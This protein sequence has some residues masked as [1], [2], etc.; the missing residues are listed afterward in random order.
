MFLFPPPSYLPSSTSPFKPIPRSL[1]HHLLLS[2][3]LSVSLSL[4]PLHYL[5]IISPST[6]LSL[7]PSPMSLVLLLYP[8][9]FMTV[10]CLWSLNSL[11]PSSKNPRRRCDPGGPP[12]TNREE[13][14]DRQQ[15]PRMKWDRIPETLKGTRI[16]CRWRDGMTH[17]E[18]WVRLTDHELSGRLEREI[19][20]V[21]RH[22]TT[23]PQVVVQLRPCE[24]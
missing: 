1:C 20:P 7:P 10:I 2:T 12:K 13:E 18:R 16:Y 6:S 19:R 15:N 21:G 11:N 22:P 4:S 8:V 14:R 3:S 23:D 9:R 5:L 17:F 24:P